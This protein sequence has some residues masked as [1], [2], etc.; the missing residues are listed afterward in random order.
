ML[1]KITASIKQ[2]A[3][4]TIYGYLRCLSLNIGVW[5]KHKSSGVILLQGI[6]FS[7]FHKLI[8]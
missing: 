1:P 7:F 3:A 8:I 2:A 6:C 4:T 5:S